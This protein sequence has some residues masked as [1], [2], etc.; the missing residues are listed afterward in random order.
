MTKIKGLMSIFISIAIV[1]LIV[2]NYETILNRLDDIFSPTRDIV[3]PKANQY[4]KEDKYL[5]LEQVDDYVPY[6]Y[7]DLINIFYSA[8]NQG[9]KEFT[10]YCPQDYV[11][12]LN[13]VA[14]I[15][16]DETLLTDINNY[17]HPYNSYSTINTY[18]DN[19]GKIT[20]NIE[21]LYTE[22]E[23]KKIDNAIDMIISDVYDEDD[24]LE[25]NIKHIHDYIIDNTKYDKV[26][27]ET[28]ESKYDSSRMNGLLFE[29]YAV[30]SAYSDVMA[31]VLIKLDVPNFKISSID[32]VW[33]ALY[34]D[35]EWLHLDLT[36]DDPSTV[37]GTD[38]L[39]HDFFL[40]DDKELMKLDKDKGNHEYD[41]DFYL[42][43]NK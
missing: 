30:C 20:L 35:G 23:I 25:D 41:Y 10:F 9:W 33:N 19:T 16:K 43:F 40:I 42:E 22:D 2:L 34:I 38:V 18:Y 17:I 6:K 11:D 29:G 26:R 31:V 12:C 5:R 24:S 27:E 13:D 3:I 28:N 21:Y 15:S 39:Q 8:L 1:V 4:V 7:D 37:D 36:W 32:H 14:A